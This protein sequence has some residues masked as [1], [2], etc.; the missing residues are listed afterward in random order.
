MV[1]DFEPSMRTGF[2]GR[3]DEVVQNELLASSGAWDGIPGQEQ[4]WASNLR[5]EFHD[6]GDKTRVIVREGPSSSF[7]MQ[8]GAAIGGDT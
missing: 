4:P 3:F 1:S 2:N 5:V 6:L 7:S 8:N